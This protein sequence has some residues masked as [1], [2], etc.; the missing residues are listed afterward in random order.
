MEDKIPVHFKGDANGSGTLVD[1]YG[2]TVKFSTNENITKGSLLEITLKPP[3]EIFFL[4]SDSKVISVTN[5]GQ[6]FLVEVEFIEGKDK[7]NKLTEDDAVFSS[8]K[9]NNNI[10]VKPKLVYDTICDFESYPSWQKVVKKVEVIERQA[11]RPKI[12]RFTFNFFFK[13]VVITNEYFYNDEE[14]TLEWKMV[15]GDLKRSEGSYVIKESRMGSTAIL[16]ISVVLGFKAPKTAIDFLN[17]S[18]MYFSIQALKKEAEK[19][20]KKNH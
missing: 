13:E 5:N 16:K 11:S 10:L 1:I 9:H 7:K 12:V 17:A 14:L 3:N 20:Y 19:R 15:K 18:T 2:P 6:G 8:T 4:T